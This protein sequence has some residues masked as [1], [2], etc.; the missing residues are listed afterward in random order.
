MRGTDNSRTWLMIDIGTSQILQVDMITDNSYI[1]YIN[2][3]V[4][5][6]LDHDNYRNIVLRNDMIQYFGEL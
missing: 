6:L 5:V 4:S 3:E 1:L 2:E